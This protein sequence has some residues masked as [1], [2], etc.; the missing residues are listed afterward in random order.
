MKGA[1]A[2]SNQSPVHVQSITDVFGSQDWPLK[3]AWT[4]VEGKIIAWFLS[5]RV[6]VLSC[7]SVNQGLEEQRNEQKKKEK[8]KTMSAFLSVLAFLSCHLFRGHLK[9]SHFADKRKNF[10]M[11]LYPPPPQTKV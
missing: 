3:H 11:A 8:K 2:S 10:H 7:K 1:F 9:N 4:T 6:A 5:V